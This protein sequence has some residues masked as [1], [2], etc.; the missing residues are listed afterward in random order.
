M[1]IGI[2]IPTGNNGW[3]VS[4]T[5]PQYMPTFALNKEIV[6]KAERYGFDFAISMTRLRGF[7]GQTEF[8]DHTLES[9]TLMAGLAAVTSRIKLFAT[10][11]A[12]AVPP[13]IAA[14]M[15]S[16]IDSISYGRF[17]LNLTTDWQR[18]EYA[19]MGLWPGGD[20]VSRRYEYLGEY[21]QVLRELWTTGHSNFKGEFFQMDDCQLSPRPQADMKIICT[22]QSTEDMTFSARYADYNFSFGKGINTPTAFASTTQGL[23][24]AT[25][26]T[27]RHV[28]AYAVF[29]IIADETSAAAWEKWGRYEAGA[30]TQAI[31]QLALQGEADTASGADTNVRKMAEPSSAVNV[32]M[33]ALIGSFAEVAKMLDEV[34]TV[35]GAGGVLLTFDDFIGGVENFGR[36]IQPLMESRKAISPHL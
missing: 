29:M 27:G 17:G 4:T 11:A 14:R 2:L 18:P 25:A 24:R 15:A 28:P 16:T 30:D 10:A 9:F 21:V 36:R 26:G 1:N 33:G 12:L 8:W 23:G 35:P 7:G 20:H 13:A 31:A 3:L 32:N 6:Q 34:A 5:A 19:Q 22:G